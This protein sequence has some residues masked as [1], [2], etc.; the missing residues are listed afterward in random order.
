MNSTLLSARLRT[1]VGAFIGSLRPASEEDHDADQRREDGDER[2][3]VEAG[4]MSCQRINS[5]IGGN[6]SASIARY[7][8]VPGWVGDGGVDGRGL[9]LQA[10][11]GERHRHVLHLP[12]QETEVRDDDGRSECRKR[13]P[14]GIF[15]HVARRG[16]STRGGGGSRTARRPSSR[17]RLIW[18]VTATMPAASAKLTSTM[19]IAVGAGRCAVDAPDEAAHGDQDRGDDQATLD[20]VLGDGDLGRGAGQWRGHRECDVVHGRSPCAGAARVPAARCASSTFIRGIVVVPKPHEFTD[21]A[22]DHQADHE[23]RLGAEPAVERRSRCRGTRA[24]PERRR[25]PCRA[26]R[27]CACPARSHGD[28]ESASTVW[29]L[30]PGGLVRRARHADVESL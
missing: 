27:R 13:N 12:H 28:G 20:H 15:H 23:Q 17:A 19:A 25:C 1:P 9:G 22:E 26:C 8:L 2:D 14:T 29:F 30:R 24:S 4:K 16:R 21:E 7:S 18:A 11:V 3:L 6:S 5:L 10:G